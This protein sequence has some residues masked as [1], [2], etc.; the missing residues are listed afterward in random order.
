MNGFVARFELHETAK[1]T[2]VPEE[3]NVGERSKM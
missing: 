3:I 1:A 2:H